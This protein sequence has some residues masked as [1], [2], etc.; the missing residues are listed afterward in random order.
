MSFLC[1]TE[2]EVELGGTTR[3]V[4]WNL[5]VANGDVH[6]YRSVAVKM[7]HKNIAGAGAVVKPAAPSWPGT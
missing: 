6:R 7:W 5:G 3:R 4:A 2:P 1:L